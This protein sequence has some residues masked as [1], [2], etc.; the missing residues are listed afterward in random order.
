LTEG[1]PLAS[2]PCS[3]SNGPTTDD[4]YEFDD[5]DDS[6]QKLNVTNP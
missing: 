5:E 2:S 6:Y 4:E 1:F 3:F